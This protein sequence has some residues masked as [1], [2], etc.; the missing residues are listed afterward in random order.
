M[1]RKLGHSLLVA[2][3]AGTSL[4]G[5]SGCIVREEPAPVTVT[6]APPPPAQDEVVVQS[7]PPAEIVETPPPAPDPTFVW[8]GGFWGWNGYRY[9][10]HR[11]YWHRPP[12]GHRY[13]VHEH[14]ER[15]PRG[16][17]FIGGHWG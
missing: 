11:G 3:I 12:Y 5:L 15:G 4:G 13:W 17:I 8:V 1:L 6:P 10:W 14:W 7:P 9:V 16:Y 2:A